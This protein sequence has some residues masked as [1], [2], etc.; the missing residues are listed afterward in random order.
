MPNYAEEL[1]KLVK[2]CDP[3]TWNLRRFQ[4]RPV[5]D[6]HVTMQSHARI[7]DRI[8]ESKSTHEKLNRQLDTA[9]KQLQE[10][11]DAAIHR[12]IQEQ[13]HAVAECSRQMQ[14]IR[15][16][17]SDVRKKGVDQKN[18]HSAEVHG[19]INKYTNQ[20][21]NLEKRIQQLDSRHMWTRED[22]PA[23]ETHISSIQPTRP[24]TR[25]PP[26]RPS[27]PKSGQTNF[28]VGVVKDVRGTLSRPDAAVEGL[29][30][31][32]ASTTASPALTVPHST[33][34]SKDR[35][36]PTDKKEK[37]KHL[38]KRRY[39]YANKLEIGRMF[40][41]TQD[42]MIKYCETFKSDTFVQIDSE[43]VTYILPPR[44]VN[45][46]QMM[47]TTLDP[48]TALEHAMEQ[49]A[50]NR[51]IQLQVALGA[52][53]YFLK[54]QD[55]EDAVRL[56]P[57]FSL[58]FKNSETKRINL[59]E[60][61][62]KD[63]GT[64]EVDVQVD[65][66]TVSHDDFNRRFRYNYMTLSHKFQ[67]MNLEEHDRLIAHCNTKASASLQSQIQGTGRPEES[68]P[69]IEISRKFTV[70]TTSDEF[71]TKQLLK[72]TLDPGTA[73]AWIYDLQRQHYAKDSQLPLFKIVQIEVDPGAQAY[74]SSP[75]HQIWEEE[76]W[77]APGFQVEYHQSYTKLMTIF[78][79]I[80]NTT[81]VQAAAW[82]ELEV[83]KVRYPT[84]QSSAS[85]VPSAQTDTGSRSPFELQPSVP[86][87]ITPAVQ[88]VRDQGIKS[89][90][91]VFAIIQSWSSQNNDNSLEKC[92]RRWQA[93]KLILASLHTLAQQQQR[94]HEQATFFAL[95]VL[96]YL[97]FG[98]KGWEHTGSIRPSLYAPTCPYTNGAKNFIIS[99]VETNKCQ[100]NCYTSY[101]L[102]AAQEFGYPEIY[103]CNLPGHVNIAIADTV[104]PHRSEPTAPI[105]LEGFN[106]GE[107]R[108]REIENLL[109][110]GQTNIVTPQLYTV[111]DSGYED[112]WYTMVE[113]QE[114][115]DSFLFKYT[116]RK[117]LPTLSITPLG[118][119]FSCRYG[120]GQPAA[121]NG[122][123]NLISA[124]LY[125]ATR[126]TVSISRFEYDIDVVGHIWDIDLSSLK[127]LRT[128]AHEK[129]YFGI[130]KKDEP[131][132]EARMDS[133][134]DR[135]LTI[136]KKIIGTLEGNKDKFNGYPTAEQVC[137]I[138][139]PAS[140]N[141]IITDTLTRR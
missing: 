138:I 135:H 77:L 55:G 116:P 36:T 44:P 76:V 79:F 129:F 97:Q 92:T 128:L 134:N 90:T 29:S 87:D 10:C 75:K 120:D 54:I 35:P 80:K 20:I 105:K 57:G 83:Y 53:V 68:D 25:T 61:G 133:L 115:K 31:T 95:H 127:A 62:L 47:I 28:D 111:L 3:G 5:Q 140:Y 91:A 40:G 1:H 52:Q 38:R 22:T 107:D 60:A 26:P 23:P 42:R 78:D 50:E 7:F 93:E 30:S 18:E 101:V 114:P 124:I 73:L 8:T 48:F 112:N 13:V 41:N 89:D 113:T 71:Y 39:E 33:T 49:G 123:N 9:R 19:L 122:W 16:E 37:Y 70:Y 6:T 99:L 136:I 109:N 94:P 106:L 11:G 32:G 24:S 46:V 69:L 27:R 119:N 100:C 63:S 98:E 51:I 65:V 12:R 110:L 117:K 64:V 84:N 96:N 118:P 141:A 125:V 59:L 17:L 137:K 104:R 108:E 130:R 74:F 43:F 14:I 132:F 102:A 88:W 131:D 72:T 103:A 85:R 56:G 21:E 67:R 81:V 45:K 121:M 139:K 15:R 4:P 86:S 82:V 126:V 58:E 66:Y 34:L 2:N